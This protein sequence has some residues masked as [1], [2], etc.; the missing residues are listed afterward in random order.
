MKQ[1]SPEMF[2]GVLCALAMSLW[3]LLEYALGFHTTSPEIGQYSGFVTILFP[4]IFIYV[5]MDEY[6]STTH[7][8]LRFLDGINIGFRIALYS[9][10][11]F[12]IFLLIYSTYINP[13]WIETTLE[14]QRKKLILGGATDDEIEAFM[15]QNRSI[16]SSF[17]QAL[18]TLISS[19]SIGILITCIEIPI[20]RLFFKKN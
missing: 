2:Y 7:M 11:L 3:T 9:A 20:A 19:T 5:A 10:I 12:T 8:P 14:W 15:E 17:A 18:M 4:I 16:N 1:S 6:Q 13:H